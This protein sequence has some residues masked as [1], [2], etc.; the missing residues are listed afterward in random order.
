M[1]LEKI[2][3]LLKSPIFLVGLA[4]ASSVV[5]YFVVTKSPPQLPT[6]TLGPKCPAGFFSDTCPDGTTQ[7]VKKCPTGQLWDCNSKKCGCPSGDKLCVNGTQC[8]SPCENDTCCSASNQ[9]TKNGVVSCCPPGT[10][11]GKS[12]ASSTVNDKCAVACGNTTCG[13]GEA[14]I[15]VTNLIPSTYETLST[16]PDVTGKYQNP[17]NASDN[18]ITFCSQKTT[19][20]FSDESALPNSIGNNYPYYN[21]DTYTQ[22]GNKFGL[23]INSTDTTNDTTCYG[24]TDQ[25]GCGNNTSCKWAVL[26]DEYDSNGLVGTEVQKY[27]DHKNGVSSAGY[28]CDPGQLSL[29]RL[30]QNIGQGADCSWQ[31]CVNQSLN[32]GTVDIVWDDTAKTCNAFK[33]PPYENVG[34]QP[35]QQIQC[36]GPGLPASSCKSKNDFVSAIK[37]TAPNKPC[38]NCKDDTDI[39][40]TGS[41]AT[42]DPVSGNNAWVFNTCAPNDSAGNAVRVLG[43]GAGNCPWGCTTTDVPC[44]NTDIPPGSGNIFGDK[45]TYAGAT[46][47]VCLG[48]GRIVPQ[49][50]N[51]IYEYD[52][53]GGSTS[54]HTV[55]TCPIGSICQNSLCACIFKTVELVVGAFYIYS[56]INNQINWLTSQN[57]QCHHANFIM[58]TDV[59]QADCFAIDTGHFIWWY[60]TTP[61]T[62]GCGAVRLLLSGDVY[63]VFCDD[64]GGAAYCN[65]SDGNNLAYF[66]NGPSNQ[67]VGATQLMSNTGYNMSS[68]KYGPKL[69]GFDGNSNIPMA[70]VPYAATFY[71]VPMSLFAVPNSCTSIPT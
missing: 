58:T 46:G 3:Q 19:C 60:G 61:G 63:G 54:C 11:P 51:P 59:S 10:E 55:Q 39:I 9:I 13:D 42:C 57:S 34:F 48:D 15:K 29:G 43:I 33:V 27:M 40:Y 37:C 31:S 30:V 53:S 12:S 7:C 23:C 28:Y 2:I 49:P 41:G 25:A 62:N 22:P 6:V 17:T 47:N 38:N 50:V 21:F 24:I 26:P 45:S 35:Q 16:K 14:C 1:I 44:Y 52:T 64:S 36:T 68:D 20:S 4:V 56:I 67:A 69:V 66:W 32:Q 5:I 8:C 65:Q 18:W 70:G 71:V